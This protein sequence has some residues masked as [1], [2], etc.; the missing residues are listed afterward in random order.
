MSYRVKNGKLVKM[1]GSYTNNNDMEDTKPIEQIKPEE[2]IKK[3]NPTDKEIIEQIK[4]VRIE[5][6]PVSDSSKARE[7][8]LKKFVTFKI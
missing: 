4:K 6:K 1:G 5:N 2:P 8:R 3:K 7:E